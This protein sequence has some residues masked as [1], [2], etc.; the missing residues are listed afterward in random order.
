LI[1]SSPG[2]NGAAGARRPPRWSEIARRAELPAILQA[3]AVA[4]PAREAV[5]RD[6]N[7]R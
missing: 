2:C 3:L 6:A 4:V 7:A 5:L 1:E